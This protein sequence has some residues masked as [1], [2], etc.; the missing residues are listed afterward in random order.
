MESL[1]CI[2]KD[3]RSVTLAAIDN[4][5][6]RHTDGNSMTYP[7][8]RA[9]SGEMP[10]GLMFPDFLFV[11][12]CLNKPIPLKRNVGLTPFQFPKLCLRLETRCG[13]PHW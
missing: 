12:G 1:H 6:L 11:I 8:K 3:K 13:R 9:E 7:A 10:L 4:Y 2:K 5:K